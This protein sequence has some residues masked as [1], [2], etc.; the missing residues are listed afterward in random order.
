MKYTIPPRNASIP[1]SPDRLRT[2][3]VTT[4]CPLWWGV[5]TLCALC[6]PASVISVC[7]FSSS[8]AQPPESSRVARC[9]ALAVEEAP[10]GDSVKRGGAC[11]RPRWTLGVHRFRCF[12]S[13]ATHTEP[14]RRG[15]GWPPGS[16]DAYSELFD[17]VHR[18]IGAEKAAGLRPP[19]VGGPCATGA[20]TD[21]GPNA[22]APQPQA[23][24]PPDLPRRRWRLRSKTLS[25]AHRSRRN[26]CRRSAPS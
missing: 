17:S 19:E 12:L 4:G 6:P 13:P 21:G 11:P 18:A 26:S 9:A 5:C 10:A 24:C 14:T 8:S 20:S 15:Y 1:C 25:A 23:C 3:P 22:F 2:L 7:V 16:G